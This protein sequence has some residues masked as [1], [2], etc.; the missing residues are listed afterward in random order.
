VPLVL[1]VTSSDWPVGEPGAPAL[2]A[3][4]ADRGLDSRW[5]RWDDPAVDWAAADLVAVRSAW[6]YTARAGD[7]VAWAR[8]V[9][10]TTPLLNGADVFAWNVDKVYLAALD[11]VP[12]VPTRSAVDVA[13]LRRG[14]AEFGTAVVKPRVGAGG[15]GVLVVDDPGDPRLGA[16]MPAE[17]PEL[18]DATGPWV[19]QPLVASVRTEGETSVFVLDGR[20]VAQFDKLP[21]GEE[22][23][24]HEHFG[25]TTAHVPLR[26]EAAG[27]A[28]RAMAC[29]GEL[30]GRPLDYGRVDMMRL[31]DGTLA[32][33]ELEV[34]EPG[35]Y[36]DVLPGNALPFVD[37]LL[38]RL[39]AATD[40]PPGR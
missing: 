33:G 2:D 6:D 25:G 13:A 21:G 9:E 11:G 23:R 30:L 40:S 37:L 10:A 4:L 38:A 14:V 24:V 29:A 34:T 3:A 15:A 16:T 35:L 5:V 36:L 39:G 19:V 1:L 28:Q 18:R 27:L 31:A 7:F 32:V 26:P 22:I 17:F 12:V 20:A 8:T